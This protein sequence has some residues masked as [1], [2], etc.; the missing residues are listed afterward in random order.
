MERGEGGGLN[1]ENTIMSIWSFKRKRYPYGSHD[2][3]SRLFYHGFIQQWGVYYWNTYSPV[4]NCMSVID[5]I[6]LSIIRDIHTKSVGFVR[7]YT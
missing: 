6:T 7:A 2:Q 1:V 5:M 3:K 4:F